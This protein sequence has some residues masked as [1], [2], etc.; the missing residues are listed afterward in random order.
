MG[1]NDNNTAN[2]NVFLKLIFAIKMKNQNLNTKKI[3]NYYLS[4]FWMK[5]ENFNGFLNFEILSSFLKKNL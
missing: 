3:K 5:V 2:V 4:E 1:I